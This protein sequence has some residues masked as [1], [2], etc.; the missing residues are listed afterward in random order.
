MTAR[1]PLAFALVALGGALGACLRHAVTVA[2]T[3]SWPRGTMVVNVSGCFVMGLLLG[4]FGN[5]IPEGVRLFAAV[6][7]LGGYTTFSAFGADVV[8]GLEARRAMAFGY[9]AGTVV[10]GI[11]AVVVGQRLG[12]WVRR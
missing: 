5:R 11:A 10:F 6:G 2:A 4:L 7:V 1:E 3:S 9:A 12:A 8:L